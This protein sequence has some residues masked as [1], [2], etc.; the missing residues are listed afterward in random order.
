VIEGNH[1]DDPG[2]LN[3]SY[4]LPMRRHH[5]HPPRELTSYLR[6]LASRVDLVVVDGSP[7]PVRSAHA[8]AW[9]HLPL[10]HVGPGAG[11][12][13]LNGKVAGVLT[14]LRL[15]RCERVIVADDDVRYDEAGLRRVVGLLDAGGPPRPP[16]RRGGGRRRRSA[17]RAARR[18][19]RR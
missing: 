11:V 4:I 9:R 18:S 7:G 14:G 15:A 5:G 16:R 12:A 10:R 2:G 1:R 3:A 19:G 6:W 13:A 8:E 17:V